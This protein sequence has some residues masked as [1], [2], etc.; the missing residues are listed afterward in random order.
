MNFEQNETQEYWICVWILTRLFASCQL[1]FLVSSSGEMMTSTLW[2]M[3]SL[4]LPTAREHWYRPRVKSYES[5]D[6]QTVLCWPASWWVIGERVRILPLSESCTVVFLTKL[7]LRI[8][9]PSAIRLF[10]RSSFLHIMFGRNSSDESL[11]T[12]VRSFVKI[13]IF[14]IGEVFQWIRR[15]NIILRTLYQPDRSVKKHSITRVCPGSIL[16]FFPCDSIF[17][18]YP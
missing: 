18:A 10:L 16:K 12:L 3:A 4:V 15:F 17:G 11:T 14:D 8:L 7:M 6:S 9:S 13:G 2:T 1:M 5:G